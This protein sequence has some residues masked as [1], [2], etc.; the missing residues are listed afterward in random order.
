[1]TDRGV[2]K[3]EPLLSDSYFFVRDFFEEFFHSRLGFYAASMSWSTI[4]FIIPFMVILLVLF[5]YMPIFDRAYMEI[6]KLLAHSL[7]SS[8][9]TTIMNYLD[10]FVQNADRLGYIGLIYAL[11]AVLL[12]FRD[13]DFIVND[14]FETPQRR[15]ADAVKTYFGLLLLL[16]FMLGGSF[17]ISSTIERMTEN[18]EIASSIHIYLV[19]PYLIIWMLFYLAYQFS[20]QVSVGKKE[21][22]ISSFIA[23]ALWYLAKSLFIYYILYN[24]T[25]TTIY[26]GLSTLLFFFLWIYISWAIFLHGLRFCY[27]LY[28]KNR[29]ESSSGN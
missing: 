26:G 1:M 19:L 6:H 8:D 13:Y 22:V 15:L 29:Y 20:P 5:T 3:R 11:V 24:K 9:T 17:W 4:F 10:R 25:Y 18:L 21:A 16:P 7:V 23:S 27:L 2:R 12:F 28:K 14:I